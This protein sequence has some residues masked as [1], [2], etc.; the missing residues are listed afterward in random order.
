[1]RSFLVKRLKRPVI[2]AAASVLILRGL[3][4]ASRFL[5]SLLLARM[6]LPEEFGEYGLFTAIL[7]YALLGMGLEFYSYMYREMVPAPPERRVQI[8]ADEMALGAVS[9]VAIAFLAGFAVL[10][11]LLSV[12]STLWLLL[13]LATDHV[14]LEATRFLVI[15]SRPIKAYMTVFLRGGV[16][17]YVLAALMYFVPS[18]RTLETVLIAWALGGLSA[19]V[20]AAV[21][22]S[23]LPWSGLKG[24]STDWAWVRNGLRVA[25]PF[26]IASAGAQLLTYVDRFIID[27]FQGRETLGLYTFYS[28]IAIGL[29]SLGASVSHQ[30]LPK[31]IEGYNE[32]P[33]AYR[34][35]LRTFFV[36][37]SGVM[38]AVV[39]IS[40]LAMKPLL[41]LAGL[42]AYA[43]SVSV[44]WLMLPGVLLRG[45]ADVPSYAVYSAGDDK[46]LL[47]CNIASAAVSIALN[48]LLIP[49][50]GIHG[51]AL[52]STVASASL[53]CG[54]WYLARRRISSNDTRHATG[55][56]R[57]AEEPGG[58]S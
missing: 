15:S 1:M 26:M 54:L 19:V 58:A 20:F 23:N 33:Q 39:A 53:F 46:S 14:S 12:S 57:T 4:L 48:F 29:L 45:I 5:L 17:V 18:T 43:A 7:A 36:A 50:L 3:T 31:V 27:H 11:G 30:Y 2:V 55:G 8:I 16:W 37:L 34:A 47:Y 10:G 56:S 22:M 44:F 25:R 40:G 49:T 32:S 28:T 9:F 6:L 42:D 41:S 13:I 38:A 51:A 21:V 52:S 35:S 24:R